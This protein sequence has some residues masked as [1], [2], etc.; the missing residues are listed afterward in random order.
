MNL[1]RQVSHALDAEHRTSL[2]LL[3]RVEQA[4][5]RGSRA[6]EARNPEFA[7]LA[8]AFARHVE[9]DIGRHF[10]FEERELFPRLAA[11]GEGDIA[12]LLQDEHRAIREVAAELLPLVHAAIA[13]TL[14]R[15]GAEALKRGALEM[16]E[17]QVAHIQKE[18]LALLPVLDELLDDDADQ[19]L[20]LRY[21]TT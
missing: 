1:Q 11:A 3:G 17:R 15:S 14:D 19:E 12:G 6:G 5:V 9:Q 13:G 16:V 20:A 7:P 4:L 2:E 18:T 8:A 10:D 21:A